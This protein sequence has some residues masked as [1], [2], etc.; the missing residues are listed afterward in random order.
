MLAGGVPEQ[1]VV[2]VDIGG[3][4]THIRWSR[5]GEDRDRVLPTE[6]WRR[7]GNVADGQRLLELLSDTPDG[8]PIVAIGIGAHGCD[9]DEDCRAFA[10]TLRRLTET[11]LA[12]VNDAELLQLA[13]GKRGGI[14]VVVGTGSIAVT[15]RRDGTMLVAGG[16]GWILGDEGSAPA[17]V[18]E[19][20]RAVRNSIDL[21][22]R[23]DEL[24]TA[25][26]KS[27]DAD[28]FAYFG[29][30]LEALGTASAWG[31]HARAVFDAASA[32]SKLATAVIR[33]AAVALAM[34]V[35]RLADRG[36]AADEV[37]AGGS[38]VVGQ[39]M[40]YAMF[41]E[42]LERILPASRLTLLDAAPVTGAIALA[43]RTLEAAGGHP[44]PHAGAGGI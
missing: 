34:L 25:L 41:S 10:T 26:C 9:T 44:A 43:Y 11:P 40:L 15:R 23:P 24:Y 36:A 1:Y 29:R 18:R 5:A 4:K 13:A 27:L 6:N 42:E 16:W 38:V 33:Q 12:I 21:G 39:P 14:G 2:G 20:A 35:K 8:S 19:A 7:R 31:E 17:I 22:Q 3:T 32:G 28:S 30:R 37:V